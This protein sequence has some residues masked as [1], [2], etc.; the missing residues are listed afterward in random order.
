MSLHDEERKQTR[1][2]WTY[3]MAP[4]DGWPAFTQASQWL[5]AD[6]VYDP[7]LEGMRDQEREERVTLILDAVLALQRHTNWEGDGKWFVVSLPDGDESFPETMLIVKQF[8][9]GTTF[10]VSTIQIPWLSHRLMMDRKTADKVRA[11]DPMP[12]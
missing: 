7:C 4:I 11:G 1:R 5:A 9:N 8:N 3:E 6:D 2:L 12:M 10:A